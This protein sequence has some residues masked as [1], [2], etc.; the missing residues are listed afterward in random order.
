MN[1]RENIPDPSPAEGRPLLALP[2]QVWTKVLLYRELGREG[3]RKAD[4]ARMLGID[5]KGVDRLFKLS[6][7]SRWDQVEAAFLALGV[8]LIPDV[9]V[10]R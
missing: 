3:R 7:C 9:R 6:H 10:V 4:L 8:R 1:D 2:S 5:Q